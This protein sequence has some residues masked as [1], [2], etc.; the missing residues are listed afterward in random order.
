[1]AFA[2]NGMEGAHRV[3]CSNLDYD[4]RL[5]LFQVWARSQESQ[6]TS[7]RRT[8]LRPSLVCL[9]GCR[10]I[11]RRHAR[12]VRTGA[13]RTGHPT[14]QGRGRVRRG[15]VNS[16]E[17]SIPVIPMGSGAAAMLPAAFGRLALAVIA[18]AGDKSVPIKNSLNLYK[19]T[20]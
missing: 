9:S 17:S 4:G 12:Q 19:P 14:Y 11:L 6:G 3:V 20:G 10:G 16:S 5:R 1:M 7:G 13:R 2:G 15:R 8:G 18:F